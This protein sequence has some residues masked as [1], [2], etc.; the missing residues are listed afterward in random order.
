MRFQ[1]KVAIITGAASGMGQLAAKLFIEEGGFVVMTDIN[2]DAVTAA[3]TEL[4]PDHQQAVGVQAD[5]RL[6]EEVQQVADEAMKKFGRIDVLMNF[7]GGAES[8]VLN[9]H[10]PFY[11]MPV[12]VIDWGLDV[13]LKGAVYF[14]RAVMGQMVQQ[15]SGV[16]INLG[17]ISG[18]EGSGGAVNYSA[19]KSGIIGLTKSLALSGAKQGVRAC[20]VSPGPVLTRPG[21]A[22]MKTRLGRA[23]D[24]EEVVDLI[25][26]LCSDKAGF[27]TGSNYLIDGGRS[28]GGMD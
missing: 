27:I 12:E 1:N 18:V 7:A 4:S 3:A 17:S 11:E 22:N 10:K 14:C 8:R 6:Y 5:V 26:Y 2:A 20:C 21:M 19:A 28:C 24:P 13:N 16:I 9:C 15:Q 23:A 25:L